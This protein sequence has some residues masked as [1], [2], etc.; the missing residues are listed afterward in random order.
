MPLR[1]PLKFRTWESSRKAIAFPG[2][3]RGKEIIC[4]LSEEALT[5][6]CGAVAA[7]PEPAY[8]AFDSHRATIERLAS[9]K[10]DAGHL[11][12]DGTVLIGS[13]DFR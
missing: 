4:R 9:R 6:C 3:V 5:Q 12:A 2:E 13:G 8:R 1:F 10:Y 11:E 7:R